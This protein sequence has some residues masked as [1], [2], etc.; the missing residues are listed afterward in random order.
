MRDGHPSLRVVEVP[1]QG[2]AP[3]LADAPT[4]AHIS[5]FIDAQS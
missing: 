3:L 4:I 1:N 5:A 2:H